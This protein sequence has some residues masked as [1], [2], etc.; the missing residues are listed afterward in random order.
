MSMH[1]FLYNWYLQNPCT[2]MSV[3]NGKMKQNVFHIFWTYFFKSGF[4]FLSLPLAVYS[5]VFSCSYHFFLTKQNI[6]FP[7]FIQMNI[8]IPR[9]CD[10]SIL[11]T[12]QQIE[13]PRGVPFLRV[14]WFSITEPYQLLVKHVVCRGS[15]FSLLSSEPFRTFYLIEG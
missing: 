13:P 9:N 15:H 1:S 12:N 10:L 2:N 11:E 8:L 4:H 5:Q 6:I 3:C 7:F 14:E